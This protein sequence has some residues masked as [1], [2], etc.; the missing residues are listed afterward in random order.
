MESL[1]QADEYSHFFE[2]RLDLF[3]GPIDLLLHLVKQREL[4]LEKVSLAEITGQYLTCIEHARGLD[5][6]IAG[7]YLVI[8]ATLLSIKSSILLN[9]PVELIED[10]EGNLTNPHDELLRRL[11]EHEIY[12][13]GAFMLSCRKMLNIDVFAPPSMLDDVEPP[14]T[15]YRQHDPILLGLAF[16]KVLENIPASSSLTITF[17]AVS[18]VDRMMTMMDTLKRAQGKVAFATLVQ[19][20]TS[21]SSLIGSF[22]ALLELCKRQAIFVF[23]DEV[24]KEIFVALSEAEFSTTG[25]SSEFDVQPATAAEGGH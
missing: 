22:C 6:D 11:R 4:P 23:Q 12:K 19:D 17:E 14:P 7:E 21:R 16:K 1:N 15:K 3:D 8:A 24:F 10:E 13:H 25:L 18:I 5:L 2:V 20:A 9:E